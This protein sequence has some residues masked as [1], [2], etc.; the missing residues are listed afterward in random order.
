MGKAT[1]Q[2]V[3]KSPVKGTPPTKSQG[4]TQTGIPDNEHENA[5]LQLVQS[6]EDFK[7]KLQGLLELATEVQAAPLPSK[8]DSIQALLENHQLAL[9][10]KSTLQEQLAKKDEEIE[11]WK[12]NLTDLRR[13]M[14]EEEKKYQQV[15][16][17]MQKEG[18]HI[19]AEN[20]Q[21]RVDI[22]NLIQRHENDKIVHERQM[23]VEMDAK[24][25]A[26]EFEQR[27]KLNA[28]EAQLSECQQELCESLEAFEHSKSQNT[29]ITLEKQKMERDMKRMER[30]YVY[31]RERFD[32]LFC[33]DDDLNL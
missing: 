29:C 26:L 22:Q 21:Y 14:K 33:K 12:T 8:L 5:A 1:K 13:H 9:G 16:D 6:I 15:L 7:A 31:E 19:K 23:K 32:R 11:L 4:P 18:D 30:E 25:S 24:M 2:T 3:G 10:E 27:E 20:E 17:E 28:L